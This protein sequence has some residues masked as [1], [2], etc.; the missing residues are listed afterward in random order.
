MNIPIEKIW[1][2]GGNAK[3][4]A[5]EIAQSNL[6]TKEI[7]EVTEGLVLRGTWAWLLQNL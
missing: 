7:L 3:V 6:P 4:L 1:I 2:D 5:K